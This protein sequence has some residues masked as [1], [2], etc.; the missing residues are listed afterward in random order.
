MYSHQ[1]QHQQETDLKDQLPYLWPYIGGSRQAK[2]AASRATDKDL[3]QLVFT[4]RFFSQIVFFR[5]PKF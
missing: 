2:T 5:I 4:T 3:G 1:N